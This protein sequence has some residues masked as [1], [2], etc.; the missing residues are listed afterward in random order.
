MK[1]FL[2]FIALVLGLAA[3]GGPETTGEEMPQD[4]EGKR[5]L[6]Q[7]KRAELKE[8]TNQITT[9]ENDIAELDPNFRA[10]QGRLV[11]TIPVQRT[12]FAHFV[13]IQGAVEADDLT[14]VTSEIAGRI[15]T[16]KFDEGDA[17]S[18]GQLVATLDLEQLN[19]QIA[20]LETSLDLAKTVFERQSRLW[21]Q[22]IGSEI[23][24]LEAKNNKERI[25]KSLETLQFQLDKGKVYAPASGVVERVVLQSG[26]LASPGMPILQILNTNK[27]KVVANVPENY[28]RAVNRGDRVKVEFPALGEEQ[29][30]RINLIGR[31][32]DPSNRTFSVEANISTKGG[33]IKP[34]L[35]AIMYLK[36]KEENDVVTVPLQTVQQEVSG[37][38]FVFIRA[39][40]EE[41]PIAKKVYVQTGSSYN[42]HMVITDGLKGGEELIMEGAR[43][44]AENELLEILPQGGNAKT[45]S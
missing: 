23:Q 21:E 9:L 10:K 26:E 38:D 30:A 29:D 36:D 12:D 14:D 3:C 45:E 6:L 18:K 42:G 37:R 16:L 8:L 34:N 31:T 20:E 44:L 19:K 35:L 7:T 11:T 4:L 24:Y 27:L 1:Y 39:D 43:G 25:E 32:I 17:I 22:N 33:M 5:Q 15:L 13:E 40:S 2:Q 28:L 41:G